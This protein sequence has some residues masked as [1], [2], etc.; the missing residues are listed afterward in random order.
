MANP[1]D[2]MATNIAA[3][4]K[5]LAAESKL[6][7]DLGL[8]G[9]AVDRTPIV[10]LVASIAYDQ[11]IP[12]SVDVEAGQ[13]GKNLW[14][15]PSAA[16]RARAVIVV[17]RFGAGGILINPDGNPLPFPLATALAASPA[18]FFYTNPSGTSL[19]VDVDGTPT[20]T[21]QGIQK[22]TVDTETEARFD[23]FVFI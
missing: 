6:E 10:N 14:E 3:S 2:P 4:G 15:A 9:S 11:A 17:C 7:F 16:L 13:K 1:I 18:W 23:G 8:N 5:V 20:S 12:F 21:G 22:V 19:I